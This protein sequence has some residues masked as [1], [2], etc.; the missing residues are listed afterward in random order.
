MT[1]VLDLSGAPRIVDLETGEVFA[2]YMPPQPKPSTLEER[3]VIAL[4]KLAMT[5]QEKGVHEYFAAQRAIGGPR[6]RAE[7][8]F[9]R[10]ILDYY[11]NV[12]RSER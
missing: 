12:P 8:D 4:E 5:P 2:E 6:D 1:R 9:M 10:K 7:D 3:A 11:E